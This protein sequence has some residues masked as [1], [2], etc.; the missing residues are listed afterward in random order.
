MIRPSK[1][2]CKN[3][4]SKEHTVS[5]CPEREAT[6]KVHEIVRYK[7]TGEFCKNDEVI[8]KIVE[9]LK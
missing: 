8:Q 4:A 6:N 7:H 5:E 2:A 9:W 3:C 1:K